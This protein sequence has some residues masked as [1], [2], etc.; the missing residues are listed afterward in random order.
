VL[1]I[2]MQFAILLLG[3]LLFVFYLFQQ[4]PI[5]FNE[6]A[7]A[8][9]PVEVRVPMEK[10]YTETFAAREVVLKAALSDRAAR[11]E[12][13]EGRRAE[14]R[15]LSEAMNTQRAAFK[16]AMLKTNPGADTQDADYVFLGFVLRYLPSGLVGLLIA[17]IFFAA[18]SSTASELNA[19]ASTTMVDGYKVLINGDASDAHY[20][21]VSRILTLCWGAIAIGFAMTLTLFENLIEA[22]NIIGSLFYGTILGLFLIAFFFK[23]VGGNAAFIA[24][25]CAEL[26]VLA[27]YFS[28]LKIGYLWF[29]LVGCVLAIGI[30]AVL[31]SILNLNGVTPAARTIPDNE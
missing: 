2:P 14:I 29:N 18:M 11:N 30:A 21:W 20:V 31:Q 3:V 15:E 16:T 28:P 19:L 7:L 25:I 6:A 22:V 23:R 24:G 13:A 5:F 8:Q 17:V 10:K 1:K 12:I 9:V 27:L 4:P 26:I